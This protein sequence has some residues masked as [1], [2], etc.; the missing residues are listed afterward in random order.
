MNSRQDLVSQ[1]SHEFLQGARNRGESTS[2]HYNVA[3][4]G[5]LAVDTI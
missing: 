1:V 5:M 4:P 2:M 3:M